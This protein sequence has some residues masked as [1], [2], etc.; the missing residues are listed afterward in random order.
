MTDSLQ[1]VLVEVREVLQRLLDADRDA[2]EFGLKDSMDNEGEA[3]QSADFASLIIDARHAAVRLDQALAS[4]VGEGEGGSSS[5][6]SATEG[7]AAFRPA[8]AAPSGDLFENC[9]VCDRR[10]VRWDPCEHTPEE[11]A[12]AAAN[13]ILQA[14]KPDISRALSALFPATSNAPDGAGRDPRP[15]RE[16][17]AKASG[18]GMTSNPTGATP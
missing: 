8:D 5:S 13:R 18:P 4:R 6:E 10:R 1:E 12:E 2:P 3:Y 17:D 16:T 11:H 14:V 9:P 7:T 15:H